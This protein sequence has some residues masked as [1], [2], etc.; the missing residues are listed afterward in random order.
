MTTL[1]YATKGNASPQEKPKVYFTCHPSDFEKSFQR[2][3]N[4]LFDVADC[5]VFYSE[6]MSQPFTE[7]ECNLDLRKM[8]LFVIPVTFK[9]LSEDNRAMLQDF[10][11][12]QKEHIP[13][14][15]IMLDRGID[16]LYSRKDRFGELQYLDPEGYDGTGKT[17]KEKLGL[18]LQSVLVGNET[19]EKI[20]AA[21]D[22]YVFLSYRKKDRKHADELMRLIHADPICRDIAIWY[23]EYLIPG[24][25]FN[26]V[27]AKAMQ[28]SRLFTLLVTPNLINEENY[29]HSIEY[30]EALK[31]GKTIVPAEMVDTDREE[32][33]KKYEG[34][35]NCFNAREDEEFKTGIL[36]AIRELALQND[37]D[38]THNYLI[39][40]AYLEGID[41]EVN[42]ERAVNLISLAGETEL[43]EAMTKLR[44]MY[45]EGS[46]VQ[47]DY[48]LAV[49]WA[50]KLSSFYA[51]TVGKRN[52]DTIKALFELSE[53]Y[54]R[55]GRYSEEQVVCE[56]VYKLRK[57]IL[58]ERH[59]DTLE[60]LANLSF[61][62]SNLGEHQ[63][64][65]ELNEQ[66]YQLQREVLGETHHNTLISLNNLAVKC[67]YVGQYDK[68]L[69]LSEK[70][71][72]L[73]KEI[74]GEKHIQTL[75]ALYNLS[76]AYAR[77]KNYKKSIEIIEAIYPQLV[78]SLGEKHPTTLWILR[79][80]AVYYYQIGNLQKSFEISEKAY[81]M[82]KEVL[83]ENH[84]E[85]IGTLVN[86][87]SSYGNLGN[88][89]KAL[90]LKEKAYSQTKAVLCDKHPNTLNTLVNLVDS[91][92]CVNDYKNAYECLNTAYT[93]GVEV[94]G[95]KSSYI[96]NVINRINN[97]AVECREHGFYQQALEYSESAYSMKLKLYGE[98]DP[99]TLISLCTIASVYD[100]LGDYASAVELGEKVYLMRKEVLGE[101]NARTRL[102]MNNLAQYYE[103]NGNSQ[104]ATEIRNELSELQKV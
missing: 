99:I 75:Y 8:N 92:R 39:G 74:S 26:D 20:R 37:D 59:P 83:G 5:A 7:E 61:A 66:A 56:E 44:D 49:Y 84:P 93:L 25:S 68:A 47:L 10:T 87:A 79:N 11:Y 63:K 96:I 3:C 29:V 17:Y 97:L 78:D 89:E 76:T 73:R 103:N 101:T 48:D 100:K 82:Q 60:A 86:L 13:V 64:A 88:N 45:T 95:E 72:I 14:L 104:K 32:L 31:S 51:R 90:E 2:I 19:A 94:L 50:E 98:K 35:V 43:P 55:A 58:G 40:L 81:E 15:P 21:F 42:R 80:S 22:A 102:S 41:V 9:L 67:G 65:L 91:Y 4:D 18:F 53:C 27:I 12:A 85:T 38:P 36:G 46:N 23:D 34:L 52:S 54:R 77:L 71:Y 28:K 70:A 6:D 24:E 62:L 30:P 33:C 16:E 1:L 57:E 69:E